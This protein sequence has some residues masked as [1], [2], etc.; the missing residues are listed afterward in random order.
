MIASY[1]PGCDD[2]ELLQSLNDVYRRVGASL[3]GLR[4]SLR[5]DSYSPTGPLVRKATAPLELP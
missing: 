3:A 5:L 4:R 1:N 2:E